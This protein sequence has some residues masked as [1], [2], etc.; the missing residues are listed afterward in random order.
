MD[1][2]SLEKNQLVLT[3]EG[4]KALEEKLDYLKTVRRPEVA[5]RIKQAIE[6][7][8]LSENSEYDGAK[9][10]QAFIEGEIMNIE[11]R[12]RSVRIIDK[13]EITTD[14]VGIGTIVRVL[15]IDEDIEEEYMIVGSTE[16]DAANMKISNES[17]MGIAFI[18]QAVG[19][20]VNVM[21]PAGVVKFKI[22]EIRK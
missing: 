4:L 18:G 22:L 1:I 10:E 2:A 9:N 17:P 20:E 7:G 19:D 16:A 13:D 12:L 3:P 8:D 5:E 21:A 15:D 14:F 11:A 6:F